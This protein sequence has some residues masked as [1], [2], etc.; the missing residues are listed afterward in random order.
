MRIKP[1]IWMLVAAMVLFALACAGKAPSPV[2]QT[3]PLAARSSAAQPP[4]E[5]EALPSN[6][7]KAELTIIE[8]PAKLR[9][10]QKETVRV[11][12]KNAS[13]MMWW[14]RG[15][16][17]NPRSDNKFYL[18]AGNRWL[19]ADGTLQTNMDG[20]YGLGKDLKPGEEIEVPLVITAPKD[21]GEYTLEVDLLQE[22]VAWFSDKGSPTAKAKIA[23]V[24]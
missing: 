13:E 9:S 22:Q 19:K 23:V 18:A 16:P 15:A 4:S 12:I 10:G 24:K 1:F 6:A 7:F 20:R 14:A 8:P 2:V 3:Q 5:P 21:P 17:V 11:K